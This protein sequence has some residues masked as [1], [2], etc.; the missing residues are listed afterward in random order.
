MAVA[1]AQLLASAAPGANALQGMNLANPPVHRRAEHAEINQRMLKKRRPQ[2]GDN[3]PP[4][5]AVNDPTPS[6]ASSIPTQTST[7]QTSTRQTTSA[8]PTSSTPSIIDQLSQ[9]INGSTT[10][11]KTTSSIPTTTS[12]PPTSTQA[13]TSTPTL[14]NAS[15]TT[16]ATGGVVYL[17]VP[18]AD[19][20]STVDNSK[21]ESTSFLPHSVVIGLIVT[22]SC[23]A[24]AAAIWTIV[25][26]WKFSPSRH[27]ED[28]LEP[29]NWEPK[30][31]SGIDHDPTAAAL[32]RAGSHSGTRPSSYMSGDDHGSVRNMSNTQH[33]PISM[34]P[35]FP[36][37]HDFTAGPAGAGGYVDMHRGP[38][39]APNAAYG[40]AAYGGQ[41]ETPNPYDAYDY[42]NT[43]YGQRRY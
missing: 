38:S 42:N 20:S 32:A 35:D 18:A 30:G 13:P 39:P 43:G 28:R 24:G 37:A 25:R 14:T 15:R 19:A 7:Q 22:A 17:T 5:N 1:M 31:G 21:N 9:L 8:T 16:N 36:P 41:Y 10:T 26:K 4:I 2:T 12:Q 3:A 33:E 27:F 6:G 40:G 23:I 29:I 34:A 11:T